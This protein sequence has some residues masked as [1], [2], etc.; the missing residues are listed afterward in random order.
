MLQ[1]KQTMRSHRMKTKIKKQPKMKRRIKLKSISR[2]R[3]GVNMCGGFAIAMHE[4]LPSPDKSTVESTLP[5]GFMATNLIQLFL[6]CP[7]HIC[8]TPKPKH[9]APFSNQNQ[10]CL[11]TSGS[12]KAI[13]SFAI[14]RIQ[15]Q[16][17]DASIIV[18]CDS[19]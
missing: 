17:H 16:P 8:G 2:F 12:L 18:L 1:R 5:T 3:I 14:D 11:N 10:R 7:Q 9:I 13:I 15:R 19:I 4:S 6:H